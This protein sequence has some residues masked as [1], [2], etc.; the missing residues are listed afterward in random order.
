MVVGGLLVLLGVYTA[1]CECWG[2]MVSRWNSNAW[3]SQLRW[4][5]GVNSLEFQLVLYQLFHVSQWSKLNHLSILLDGVLWLQ[6]LQKV[7]GM[8]WWMAFLVLQFVFQTSSFVN[9]TTAMFLTSCYVALSHLPLPFLT[10]EWIPVALIVLPAVRA[11]G[12]ALWEPAPPLLFGN[13]SLEF[14][15]TTRP[16]G[17]VFFQYA[18]KQHWSVLLWTPFIGWLSE[19][20]AGLPFRLLPITILSICPFKTWLLPNSIDWKH[21]QDISQQILQHGWT[22]WHVT[23]KLYIIPP[24]GKTYQQN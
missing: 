8:E 21:I 16:S 9:V 24:S 10:V 3:S 22:A 1:L 4:N 11:T 17:L 20:Q 13:D 23:N 6:W 15:S 12:H 14:R 18:Q 19:L 2:G 5:R 7:C